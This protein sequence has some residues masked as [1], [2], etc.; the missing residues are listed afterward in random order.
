ML[1]DNLG[2]SLGLNPFFKCWVGLRCWRLLRDRIGSDRWSLAAERLLPFVGERKHALCGER[3][4]G[5][6][7]GGGAHG[8][9]DKS[10]PA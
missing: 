6:D 4:R 5:R 9:D 10:F 8:S 7:G 3:P 1:K 2:V